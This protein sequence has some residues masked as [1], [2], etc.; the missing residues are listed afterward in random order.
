MSGQNTFSHFSEI[1]T[2][3]WQMST[4]ENEEQNT[5]RLE[6]SLLVSL[7]E[8]LVLVIVFFLPKRRPFP[9]RMEDIERVQEQRN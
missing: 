9:D 8:L 1:I 7:Y 2:I 5:E 3:E 6:E 4:D